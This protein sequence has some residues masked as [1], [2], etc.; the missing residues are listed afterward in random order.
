MK[1]KSLA[2]WLK[3]SIILVALGG[4]FVYAGVLPMVG[5]DFIADAPWKSSWY[6]PWLI[7]IWF[8]A[9]PCYAVLVL[10]WQIAT[11]IGRDRSFTE[12]NARRLKV[13]SILAEIDS[14]FVLLVNVIFFFL[15]LNQSGLFVVNMLIVTGGI[16]IA[17]VMAVLSHL[18]Q[19]AA[20]LQAENDLTI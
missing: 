6:Y 19:K 20:E 13:V 15:G 3:V 10:G 16:V 7:F 12:D 2:N 9:L 1:Q 4:I 17:V 5:K 11:S 14:C 8:T 18:V